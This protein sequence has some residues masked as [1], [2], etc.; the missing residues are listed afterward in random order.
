MHIDWA[1]WESVMTDRKKTNER[2]RGKVKHNI[3]NNEIFYSLHA[4]I[5]ND[6]FKYIT[7]TIKR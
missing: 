4:E 1:H 5:I 6:I 3:K 7:I 2:P